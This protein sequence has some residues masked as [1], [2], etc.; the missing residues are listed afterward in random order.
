MLP[1]RKMR[2]LRLIFFT[3]R[4]TRFS[5]ARYGY[6]I[7]KK[8]SKPVNP[9]NLYFLCILIL[10]PGQLFLANSLPVPSFHVNLKSFIFVFGKSDF[11]FNIMI[12]FLSSCVIILI[13][14]M[15]IFFLFPVCLFVCILL[16]IKK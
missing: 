1:K 12:S 16:Y 8:M 11:I 15:C 10:T 2:R 13:F 6:D 4:F 5:V 9:F 7:F 3:D 14:E